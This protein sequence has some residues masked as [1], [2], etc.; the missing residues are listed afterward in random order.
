MNKVKFALATILGLSSV[1]ASAAVFSISHDIYS[2]GGGYS[3]ND[4][5][6]VNNAGAGT[7]FESVAFME[8]DLSNL[9]DYT[10][11]D[12]ATLNLE[13]YCSPWLSCTGKSGETMEISVNRILG[14]QD[15]GN[16]TDASGV[17]ALY[18]AI[19]TVAAATITVGAIGMY[20]WDITDLLAELVTGDNVGFALT[21]RNGSSDGGIYNNYFYSSIGSGMVPNVTTVPVPAAVWLFGAGLIGLVGVARR[22]S[23]LK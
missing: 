13:M 15:V 4:R 12:A 19:D 3:D 20:A 14:G 2:Y 23:N 11:G 8:F 22:K 1:N 9:G 10:V 17:A 6:I 5:M 16:V 21:A 7:S 18:A